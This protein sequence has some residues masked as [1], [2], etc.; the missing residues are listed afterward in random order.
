MTEQIITPKKPMLKTIR[1]FP[2]IGT[3]MEHQCGKAGVKGISFAPFGTVIEYVDGAITIY[4]PTIP[5]ILKEVPQVVL[6]S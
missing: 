5:Y 2:P 4:S 1:L 3:D 6:T